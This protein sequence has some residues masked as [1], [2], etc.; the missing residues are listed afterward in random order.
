MESHARD[1]AW[2]GRGES[3]A[4][5]TQDI[6]RWWQQN[7]AKRPTVKDLVEIL[8]EMGREDALSTIYE[9]YPGLQHGSSYGNTIRN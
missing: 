8:Q 6:L 5:P 3:Q 1:I 9:V 2:E 7:A 4:H